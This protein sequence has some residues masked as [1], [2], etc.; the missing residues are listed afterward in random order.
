MLY[1][2]IDAQIN[3]YLIGTGPPLL[4]IA[5]HSFPYGVDTDEP[6]D[7]LEWAKP[8]QRSVSQAFEG[9]EGII[10]LAP[11]S[12]TAV[13]TWRAVEFW[14]VQQTGDTV[15]VVAPFKEVLEEHGLRITDPSKEGYYRD[16]TSEEL[17]LLEVPLEE[18][19]K[20]IAD[21]AT[22]RATATE[23]RIA[24]GEDLPMLITDA[25]FLRP[26]YEGPGVGIIYETDAPAK[27]PPA[28]G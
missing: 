7:A 8:T 27:P 11:S 2:F 14:D 28:P 18:F 26:Y 22:R 12:T 17:A 13:E 21:A 10:F 24:I 9:R 3:E 15:T 4:T 23:G 16:L 5:V 20:I 1:C 6:E 25:N 19:E